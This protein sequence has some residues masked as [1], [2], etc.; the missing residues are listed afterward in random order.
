MKGR[1]NKRLRYLRTG[2]VDMKFESIQKDS[3]QGRQTSCIML[4]V[5]N[6]FQETVADSLT[7]V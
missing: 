1:R 5:P 2:Q 6:K 7:S 4:A 3:L